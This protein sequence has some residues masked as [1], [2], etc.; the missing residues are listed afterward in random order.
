MITGRFGSGSSP[1]LFIGAKGERLAC[2]YG[3][4]PGGEGEGT[5]T[6]TILDVLDIPPDGPPI[7]L[8]K[9][10]W[11]ADFVV[12]PEMSTGKFAGVTGSWEMIAR[13]EPFI[14]GTNGPVLYCWEGE[15]RLTFPRG[16]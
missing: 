12:K 15:G 16:R 13:S 2:D 7:L 8:V 14:R 6:L 10:V 3:D 4:E 9:A 5:L 11:V 1:F